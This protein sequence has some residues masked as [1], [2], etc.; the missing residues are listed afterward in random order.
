MTDETDPAPRPTAPAAPSLKDSPAFQGTSGQ[1]LLFLT[2][3]LAENTV[4]NVVDDVCRQVDFE[5]SVHVLPISVAALMHAD[6]VARKLEIDGHYDRVILPGW[7]QG[8]IGLLEERFS[9]PFELGPKDI[10]DLPE[11][12]GGKKEPVRLDRYDI[13]IIAEINHCPRLSDREILEIARHYR[14]DGADLID[15]GCLPGESWS[16]VGD[17]VAMLRNEG[18]RVSIDSFDRHEVQ[19]AVTAGAE[20]V[21]SGN[22]SNRDWLPKLGV[23]V[24]AIPDTPDNLDSLDATM[25]ALSAA[26]CPF[27]VDPIIEP[28]GFG[29]AR[30]L[31]RYY[32]VA[33]RHPDVA[34]MM[35]VGNISEMVEVDSAGV[36]MLLA[37]I[38]Q[39]LGIRSV[40][41]TEVINWAR[42]SVKEFDLA[43][44]LVKH[45]ID[46]RTLPKHVDPQLVILRDPK[47]KEFGEE[48]LT[49]LA[50]SLKD[51]N[52]RIFVEGGQIHVMNRDGYWRGR[53]AFEL[54]DEFVS[55][56]GPLDASHAFYLGY[57][58]SK[59]VTALT[60][61]KQYQQDQALQWGFLTIPEA[62]ALERRHRRDKSDE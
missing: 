24:V 53:D 31:A 58:L 18:F 11:W 14:D 23:E 38:C 2:G 32:D 36:N 47:L 60:L 15:V 7:C 43:R 44:R 50:A 21:L 16:R 17:V 55:Q 49:K 52:Y 54:F 59:A 45:A 48:T 25:E 19:A 46:N 27:R 34:V 62:S 8:N 26:G 29:F 4:R 12:F 1:R 33:R 40:L 28:I 30:S 41:T 51:P 61:G 3:R 22:A 39:E 9:L 35:G 57:E 5:A 10:F 37:A 6:W 13:E 42:T 56:S 20:L